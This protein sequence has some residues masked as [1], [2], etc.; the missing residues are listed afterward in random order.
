MVKLGERRPGRACAS[1]APSGPG[2]GAV[3]HGL[4]AACMGRDRV[5]TRPEVGSALVPDLV[6]GQGQGPTIGSLGRV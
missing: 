4:P 3:G 2:P 6:P 5:L 1:V